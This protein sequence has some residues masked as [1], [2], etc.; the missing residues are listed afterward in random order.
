MVGPIWLPPLVIL[1]PL[2]NAGPRVSTLESTVT[3]AEWRTL[4]GA[5]SSM[6]AQNQDSALAALQALTA[7]NTFYLMLEMGNAR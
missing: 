7:Q 3:Q 5:C 4:S 1:Q 2:C 6:L